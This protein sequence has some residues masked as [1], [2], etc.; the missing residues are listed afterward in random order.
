M[1]YTA[2]MIARMKVAMIKRVTF[3]NIKN[4]KECAKILTK[5]YQD[6]YIQN[7]LLESD[8]IKVFFNFKNNMISIRDIKLLS[9]P[10]C[11]RYISVAALSSR[12][13]LDY[14]V[15]LMTKK[16]LLNKTEAIALNIGGI[17]ILTIR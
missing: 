13:N 16:G 17:G 12:H 5:F 8:Y 3:V 4:T 6:G 10:G 11:K 1:N 9:T 7:F 14:D 15:Y 2:D